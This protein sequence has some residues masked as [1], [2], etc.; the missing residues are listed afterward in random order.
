MGFAD[1]SKTLALHMGVFPLS[2]IISFNNVLFV[3]SLNCTLISVSKIL[4][5]TKCVVL[6]TDTLFV[7]Q[8]RFSK[9]LI[10]TGEEVMGF[11]ILQTPF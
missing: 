8:E 7:L 9:T 10:R 4:K 2:E 5:Q 1:G 6:F 11:I 3:P